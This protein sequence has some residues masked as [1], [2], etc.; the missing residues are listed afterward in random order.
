MRG[1]HLS[2]ITLAL[3]SVAG[4]QDLQSL[5]GE[6]VPGLTLAE[7][8]LFLDGRTVFATPLTEA[9]GLGPIFNDPGCGSCHNHPAQGGS[10]TRVVTRFGKAG[11]PFDPL[12]HLGGSLLQ[13]QSLDI[14][15]RENVPPEADVVSNR[16]T[17]ICFGAGLLEAIPHQDIVD[18]ETNQPGHLSGFV[19]WVGDLSAPGNPPQPA[20]FGWKG[21]V[22]NVITFS[23][24]AG[25]NEMGLTSVF[26]PNENA[27]NGDLALLAACDTVADPEDVPDGGGFTKIDRFTHFQR[28]LA[29]PPQMPVSGLA[30]EAVFNSVGCAD[31]HIRDYT[32]GGA[33]EAGLSNQAIAP[34]SDFLLHDMGALG[35][36]IAQGA[37]LEEHAQTRALWGLRHRVSFLHDGRVT[38]ADWATMMDQIIQEHV[39]EGV[40]A[41]DNYNALGAAQKIELALFLASLGQAPFDY[42]DNAT[43]IGSADNDRDR[44][45]WFFIEPFFTG[46]APGSFTVNDTAAVTDV[47][48]DGDFDLREFGLFQRGFTGELVGEDPPVP[49]PADEKVN[50]RVRSGLSRIVVAPGGLVRYEVVAEADGNS[51]QGIAMVSVD[52]NFDGGVLAPC[53]TPAHGAMTNF[54]SPVGLSNPQGFGGVMSG[55]GLLQVGGAMNTI[56]NTFAPQ[57]SGAVVTG[58]GKPGSPLIVAEGS[59]IAPVVPGVYT[60]SL[61]NPM[62]NLI[63]SAADGV[64]F[65]QVQPAEAGN[66]RN[67]TIIVEAG[68]PE[69]YCA[70]K[71]SSDGCAPEIFWSGTPSLSGPDDFKIRV[72]GLVAGE[73][74]LAIFGLSAQNVPFFNGTL[75]VG[76]L[77]GRGDSVTAVGSGACEGRLDSILRQSK[78]GGPLG[79]SAGDVLHV[80]WYF[81]D[82][83]H[84]D[85][86]T[87][88]LSDAV[89]FTIKP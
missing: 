47:Q 68:G 69:I 43:L 32:T 85:G 62:A 80:Q 13:D 88:G 60:L 30:G 5:L 55:G 24:D 74:G 87:V 23:I 16:L 44:F 25:L 2:A 41:R 51:N 42:E 8:Q 53:D 58:L 54:V 28:L 39:G 45:D 17:P 38:G 75:C 33:A 89:K 70:G 84:V 3:C 67:L 78:M 6:P 1:T 15:C 77:N 65:W 19:S 11:T 49:T 20:R 64:E 46:E 22:H 4:A 66:V 86:T 34:Y 63:T 48:G 37:A 31:C 81:R 7:L 59:L 18:N 71:V 52:L 36:Q 56:N 72:K 83:A 57:P 9:E 76:N 14:A 29:A 10:A 26:L 79:L 35:D 27:P 50:Y 73:P 12:D 82:T 40:T 21:V 61:S